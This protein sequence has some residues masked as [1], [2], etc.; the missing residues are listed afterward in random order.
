MGIDVTDFVLVHFMIAF[1]I[2]D[3]DLVLV[4]VLLSSVRRP[5]VLECYGG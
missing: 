3:D 2:D 5:M 4:E 1:G